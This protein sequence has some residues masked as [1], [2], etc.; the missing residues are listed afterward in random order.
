[1]MEKQTCRKIKELQID[2]IEK[3]M[4]QFLQF[5]QNTG[6]GTH[7]T[8]G[9]HELAKEINRSLMEKVRCVLSNAR[10]ENRFGLK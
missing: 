8:N 2:N 5:G 7:F 3:Y 6:T 1:M 4:N 9:I 10:L